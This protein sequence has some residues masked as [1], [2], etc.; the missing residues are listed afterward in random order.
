MKK[1]YIVGLVILSVA[2]A[3]LV[4]TLGQAST[5]VT[6]SGAKKL[7]QKGDDTEVHVVGTLLKNEDGSPQ[8]LV[9]NPEINPNLS[10]FYIQD[11]SLEIGKVVLLRDLPTDFEKSE[12][13]VVMG[14][15]IE[16]Q[17]VASDVLLKCPSKYENTEIN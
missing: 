1:G 13:V 17:F 5:Y 6:L 7:E 4:S 9:F 2:A 12:K 3:I 8:G 15:Y 14:K 10:E 11:D 16:N